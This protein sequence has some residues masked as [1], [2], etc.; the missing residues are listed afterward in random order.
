MKVI[1][2]RRTQG[3]YS[4]ALYVAKRRKSDN[5]LIFKL[6]KTFD[7]KLGE[8][9][10]IDAARVIAHANQLP[11]DR[12][13]CQN[14]PIK[15]DIDDTVSLGDGD[16]VLF[17][18]RS[19]NDWCA[20]FL[21]N[22]YRVS[23]NQLGGFVSGAYNLSHNGSC[24]IYP[25]ACALDGALVA[26]NAT[27]MDHACVHSEVHVYGNAIIR[28]NAVIS[29][30][31]EVFGFAEIKNNAMIVDDAIVRDQATVGGRAYVGGDAV[32]LGGSQIDGNVRL[33]SG[34]YYSKIIDENERTL[35]WTKVG[36]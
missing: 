23:L 1:S 33:I 4:P 35:D 16:V 2:I 24:W 18:I 25:G 9:A 22:R 17:R 8:D 34:S 7:V 10:C 14:T 28:D 3:G 30:Q 32:V 13:V 19:L 36:F 26:A 5:F 12:Y 15:Y 6:H 31:A 21:Q 29:D 27:V 11:F 20:P